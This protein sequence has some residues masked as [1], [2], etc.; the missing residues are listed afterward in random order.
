MVYTYSSDH[1]LQATFSIHPETDG[2]KRLADH[3]AAQQLAAV[4]GTG[5]TPLPVLIE[6]PISGHTVSDEYCIIMTPPVPNFGER[7]EPVDVVIEMPNGAAPDVLKL[8]TAIS[9]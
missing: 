7:S 1:R 6:D 2:F 9:A 3:S 4:A 8:A 5:L